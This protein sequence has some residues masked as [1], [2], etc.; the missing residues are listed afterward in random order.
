LQV[1][2]ENQEIKTQIFKWKDPF[3][4]PVPFLDKC[5]QVA[6]KNWVSLESK[7]ILPARSKRKFE[8]L[9]VQ[10][11]WTW[12]RKFQ[13]KVL[14]AFLSLFYASW[15]WEMFWWKKIDLMVKKKKR[16]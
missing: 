16:K 15:R 9:Y 3:S 5:W 7:D 6:F 11:K 2:S 10:R 13:R 14:F 12:E 8:S 1:D 4:L